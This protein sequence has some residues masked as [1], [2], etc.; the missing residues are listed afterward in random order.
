M[1]DDNWTSVPIT[2]HISDPSLY[3][4]TSQSKPAFVATN[5]EQQSSAEQAAATAKPS[6]EG[7]FTRRTLII[8]ACIL[9]LVA[10]VIII[11]IMFFREAEVVKQAAKG[12]SDGKRPED[13]KEVR[14]HLHKENLAN[15]NDAELDNIIKG[16]VRANTQPVPQPTAV[17][18]TPA[19]PPVFSA[20]TENKVPP[21]EDNQQD[22]PADI[23]DQTMAATLDDELASNV[24]SAS[25]TVGPVADGPAALCGGQTL[26]GR[27][28]SRHAIVNGRCRQHN[29]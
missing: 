26:Q 2:P 14:K 6:E 3:N 13:A 29:K 17:L 8:I 7:T 27:P 4:K 11:Y 18:K 20:N 9:V 16:T 10:V 28:C 5:V 22:A 19:E 24:S 25:A 1:E 12:G 23:F 21:V 15:I